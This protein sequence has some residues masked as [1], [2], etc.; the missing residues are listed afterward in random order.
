MQDVRNVQS[1]LLEPHINLAARRAIGKDQ[2][3]ILV[4]RQQALA[5]TS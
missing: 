4:H 5:A 3:I 1:E 2:S